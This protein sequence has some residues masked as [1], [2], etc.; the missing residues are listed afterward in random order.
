MFG[1]Q[2]WM[3]RVQAKRAHAC[4]RLRA[5]ARAGDCVALSVNKVVKSLSDRL[6]S[7]VTD[8]GTR[9]AAKGRAACFHTQL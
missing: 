1:L 9:Y 2:L 7:E 8:S 3:V 4:R 5:L 6:L